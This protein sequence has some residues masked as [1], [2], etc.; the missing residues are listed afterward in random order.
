MEKNE[1][2]KKKKKVDNTKN[3]FGLC[4]TLPLPLLAHNEE[5]KREESIY[6]FIYTYM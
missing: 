6:L 5:R 4:H 2:R 1:M 3:L